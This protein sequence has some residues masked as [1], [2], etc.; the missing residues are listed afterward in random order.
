MA[1]EEQIERFIKIFDN[2]HSGHLMKKENQIKAGIG[3]V[4]RLLDES[5]E[6]VTA[7]AISEF[8]HVSTARVAVLLKKMESKGLIIKKSA[9]NDARVTIVCL[10]PCGEEKIQNL[11][12]NMRKDISQMIDKIGMERLENAFAVIKEIHVILENSKNV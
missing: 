9:P 10:T 6:P 5:K 12:Q 8:M 4:L 11:K 1:T 3:A 2:M 7:G